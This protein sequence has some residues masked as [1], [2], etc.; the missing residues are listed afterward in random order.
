MA[1]A[2]YNNIMLGIQILK[3]SLRIVSAVVPYKY[4]LT[5]K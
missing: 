4:I 5:Y 2:L 1:P 3:Y